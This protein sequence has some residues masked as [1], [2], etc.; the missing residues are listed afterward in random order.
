MTEVRE[1]AE[2]HPFRIEP[3]RT[4]LVEVSATIIEAN[5]EVTVAMAIVA[6]LIRECLDIGTRHFEV[7]ERLH[8]EISIEE[9]RRII[10]ITLIG[11][12]IILLANDTR[13]TNVRIDVFTERAPEIERCVNRS[14]ACCNLNRRIS[15][16]HIASCICI[17]LILNLIRRA[18]R[19]R[20]PVLSTQPPTMAALNRMIRRDTIDLAA[21][22]EVLHADAVPFTTDVR[23]PVMFRTE[24]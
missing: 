24:L 6:R 3:P 10:P 16:S 8:S 18:I 2:V 19:R 13:I 17:L 20:L 22:Q 1:S 14:T 7:F 11:V 15:V 9:A 12:R 23:I 4:N 21:K 5:S